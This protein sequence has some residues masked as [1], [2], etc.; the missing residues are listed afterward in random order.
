MK[1]ADILETSEGLKRK[2]PKVADD[3]QLRKALY[4][5]FIQQ[6]TSD[7]PISGLPN[8]LQKSCFQID[9]RFLNLISFVLH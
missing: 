5:W 8:D 4:V 9:C 1:F 2:S 3:E 6:R 7:T